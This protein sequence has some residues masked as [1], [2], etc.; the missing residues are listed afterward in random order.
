MLLGLKV[1]L[2]KFL[3]INA[4]TVKLGKTTHSVSKGISKWLDIIPIWWAFLK[5]CLYKMIYS[6]S[7]NMIYIHYQMAQNPSGHTVPRTQN[8]PIVL[9]ISGKIYN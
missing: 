9:R 2:I 7:S 6:V 1:F 4:M 3:N 5:V 8:H